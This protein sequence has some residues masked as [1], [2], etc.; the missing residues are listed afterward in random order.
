MRPFLSPLTLTTTEQKQTLYKLPYNED[1]QLAAAIKALGG[2]PLP[3]PRSTE[4]AGS[5]TTET[6]EGKSSESTEGTGSETTETTEDKSTET[7]EE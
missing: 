4:S 5:G 3:A 1:P 7:T 6:T 2:Q